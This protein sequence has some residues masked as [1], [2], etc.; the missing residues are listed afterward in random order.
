MMGVGIRVAPRSFP[1]PAA[2]NA[3]ERTRHQAARRVPST[4][5]QSSRGI[6]QRP[7]PV[8]DAKICT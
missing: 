5:N 8:G 2:G 6:F 1:V 7:V 4:A 3:S